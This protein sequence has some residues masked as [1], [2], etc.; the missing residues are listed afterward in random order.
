MNES[1]FNKIWNYTISVGQIITG[2]R[3]NIGFISGRAY[4]NI[5]SFFFV[6]REKISLLY[7]GKRAYIERR[8]TYDESY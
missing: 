8:K 2:K 3:R 7:G 6:R 4:G 5:G 1:I